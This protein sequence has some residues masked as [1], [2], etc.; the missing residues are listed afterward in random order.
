MQVAKLKRNC[1]SYVLASP[2]QTIANDPERSQSPSLRCEAEPH[3]TSNELGC[4][5]TLRETPN[6]LSGGWRGCS[7]LNSFAVDN[8]FADAEPLASSDRSESNLNY[9]G[10]GWLQKCR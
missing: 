9:Q 2:L 3:G 4:E 7:L 5:H 10:S 6:R 1:K 8:L